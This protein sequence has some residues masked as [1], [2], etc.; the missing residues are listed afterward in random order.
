MNSLRYLA[1]CAILSAP[2]WSQTAAELV[3]RNL[4]ARGGVDK[5]KALRTLRATGKV[6]Q[7]SMVAEV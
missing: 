7:G 3:A 5:L 2:A 4:Q 1:L 6:Q